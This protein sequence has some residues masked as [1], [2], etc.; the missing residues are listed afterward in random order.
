MLGKIEG[1]RSRGWQRMRG[2]DGIIDS[3]DMRLSMLW[4]LVIHR[5]FGGTGVH[6]VTNNWTWL[7]DSTAVRT[8]TPGAE[9]ARVPTHFVLPGSPQDK[10][11]C[12]LHTLS[13]GQSS[14]RQKDLVSVGAGPLRSCPTLSDLVDCGLSGFSVREFSR[15]EYWHVLASTG[16]HMLLEQ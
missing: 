12:H 3:M 9:A 6:G 13:L 8:I 2:L 16:F 11:L 15:Q 7:N 5:V 10:Q 1:R 4:E 14:H